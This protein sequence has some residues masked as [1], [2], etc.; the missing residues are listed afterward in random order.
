MTTSQ[1]ANQKSLE[2]LSTVEA[3]QVLPKFWK[4]TFDFRVVLASG[5]MVLDT[6]KLIYILFVVTQFMTLF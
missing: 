2:E 1:R 5:V 4:V 6:W 3:T